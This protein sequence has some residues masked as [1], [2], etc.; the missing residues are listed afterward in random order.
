MSTHTMH[1][2][3]IHICA[4]AKQMHCI[5]LAFCCCQV[6]RIC[7]S[8]PTLTL[9]SFGI[10]RDYNNLKL[11][12]Y[13][14][15]TCYNYINKLKLERKKQ[16]SNKN[17]IWNK[18]YIKCKFYDWSHLMAWHI[19]AKSEAQTVKKKRLKE[20]KKKQKQEIIKYERDKVIYSTWWIQN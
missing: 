17:I 9:K 18:L 11:L 8:H 5:C 6:Q 20:K 10:C 4:A 15:Y 3:L 14:I 13:W 1:A 2:Q 19:F 12:T 7:T 16:L